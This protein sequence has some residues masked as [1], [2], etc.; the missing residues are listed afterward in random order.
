[1]AT[2]FFLQNICLSNTRVLA[3]SRRICTE[4][5]RFFL[6]FQNKVKYQVQVTVI[7]QV[8]ARNCFTVSIFGGSE[9]LWWALRLPIPLCT[10][11]EEL[12]CPPHVGSAL[13]HVGTV[14]L[15]AAAPAT[16]RVLGSGHALLQQQVGD[17][18]AIKATFL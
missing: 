2:K 17:G 13:C 6:T 1:M 4:S 7:K 12:L 15:L 3:L 8:T 14:R 18:V 10:E 16:R 11:L 5:D 9:T